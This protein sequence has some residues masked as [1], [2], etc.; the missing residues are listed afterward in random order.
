MENLH[1]CSD[2]KHSQREEIQEHR[3]L[4][5]TIEAAERGLRA[6]QRRL[7]RQIVSATPKK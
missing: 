5:Q 7:N 3:L 1:P 2:W 6:E 4:R